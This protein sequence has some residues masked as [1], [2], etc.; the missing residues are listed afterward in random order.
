VREGVV[1]GQGLDGDEEG[2]VESEEVRVVAW[3]K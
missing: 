3:K 2:F 1:E